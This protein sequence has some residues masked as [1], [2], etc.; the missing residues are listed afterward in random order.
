M[1]QMDLS[2]PGI[3]VKLKEKKKERYDYPIS[4]FHSPHKQW[5]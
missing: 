4:T 3:D 1:D 2:G 5:M